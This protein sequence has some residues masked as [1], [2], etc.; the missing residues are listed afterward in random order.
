MSKIIMKTD[1]EYTILNNKGQE[2]FV[3]GR[4]AREAL[5]VYMKRGRFGLGST[6]S[7]TRQKDGWI[8]VSPS[9]SKT[10]ER[11]YYKMRETQYSPS[12]KQSF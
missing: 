5:G 9:S 10:L 11:T 6:W 2:V 8:I 12:M 4:N 7:M 1:K 3:H